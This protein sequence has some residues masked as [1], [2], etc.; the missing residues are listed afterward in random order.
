MGC[1]G[2]GPAQRL[3]FA[4]PPGGSAFY[5]LHVTFLPFA[6]GGTLE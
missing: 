6:E 3:P 1:S 2:G 4:D 5:R